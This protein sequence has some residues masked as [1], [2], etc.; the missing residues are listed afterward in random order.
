MV[1]FQ[2]YLTGKI[3]VT[4]KE[5]EEIRA[6][7][8][9]HF[10]QELQQLL[11]L[12]ERECR[13][14][15]ARQHIEE[16]TLQLKCPLP[17]CQRAFYDFEGCFAIVAVLAHVTSAHGDSKT[18]DRT[19]SLMSDSVASCPEEWTSYPPRCQMCVGPLKR[20]TN[21]GSLSVSRTT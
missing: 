13:V 6:H 19:R 11:A 5:K 17:G 15:A 10:D 4:W 21:N 1:I 3:E 20:P 9:Q 18:V 12:D 2:A 16:E 8:K 14:L 7:E